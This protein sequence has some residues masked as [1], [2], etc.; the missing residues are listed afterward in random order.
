MA[1]KKTI[2]LEVKS[3]IGGS[4]AELKQLKRELKNAAVGSDDFKRIFNQ[5]DD[6]E[7]KIKSAKKTS[8]DWVDS[9]EQAGGPLGALGGAINK[10]K[11]STQ[12]F[13]GALKATGIGLI[14]GLLGGLAAAFS[15]N[16]GAMKKLQPLLDG[17]SKIFQGVFR[18]VEP[19]FNT[20]VDLAIS[21][22][23]MVSKAF[24]TVYSVLT[25]TLQSFGAIGSAIGKLIKGDFA[26]AWD[27]AKSSVTNFGKNYNDSL[28]RFEDGTKELTKSEKLS[29][30]ERNAIREKEIAAKIARD[31]KEKA[32]QEKLAKEEKERFDKRQSEIDAYNVTQEE[33]QKEKD[34]LK[35]QEDAKK[36]KLDFSKGMQILQEKKSLLDQEVADEKAAAEAKAAIQDAQLNL[37]A[38]GVGFLKDIAGKNVALQKAA[39]L[40][41][42]AVAIA[43]IIINTRAANAKA[44]AA[45]PLTFGQPMV[46]INT[47]S[48]VLSVASTLLATKKALSSLGGGSV[49]S[50]PSLSGG[51]GSG[52]SGG[53]TETTQSVAPQFNVVG[54]S[55][56]SQ[57]AATLG[58]EQAPIKA[59]V[60]SNDVTTAQSLDRNIIT[61]ATLGG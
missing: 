23:P 50:A 30:E 39:L 2:E 19:L 59:Y 60:V 9:L 46:A 22:L 45:S 35:E 18:A 37:A 54:T 47:I 55:G 38:Q 7:D 11:V 21:A 28:K 31:E 13:G 25:A 42:S 14:V 33:L 6:L 8:S 43:R 32:R 58:Q 61:T 29:A 12:S 5:I 41:E 20:L 48:G 27:S 49:P 40:A 10:A 51:G 34:A 53:G 17:I 3:N 4:I 16:E 36:N 24:G 44:V 57:I 1:E 15:E 56:S 52:G 26:G